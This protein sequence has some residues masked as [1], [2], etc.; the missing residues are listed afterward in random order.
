[1]SSSE[2]GQRRTKRA[3][4]VAGQSRALA[5][6]VDTTHHEV[7]S[8]SEDAGRSAGMTVLITVAAVSWQ[9]GGALRFTLTFTC[10]LPTCSPDDDWR[11]AKRRG[12]C[13][14]SVTGTVRVSCRI[15]GEAKV[16]RQR[17]LIM[18]KS[19][20]VMALARR[21]MANL[22]GERRGALTHPVY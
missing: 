5:N 4:A 6:T 13:T 1:V 10:R 3:T 12:G 15:W 7:R 8:E 14:H 17:V 11:Q 20:T 21:Q 2:L 19:R 22:G 18:K 16:S 9:H